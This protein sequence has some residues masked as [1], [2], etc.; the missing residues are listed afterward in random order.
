VLDGAIHS[1]DQAAALA[2]ALLEAQAA[3]L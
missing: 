3:Y 2:D 1:L